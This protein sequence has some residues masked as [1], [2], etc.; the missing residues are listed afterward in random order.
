MD[1]CV[2]RLG[3]E[4]CECSGVNGACEWRRVHEGVYMKACEWARVDRGVRIQVGG[5]PSPGGAGATSMH[6]AV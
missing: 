1:R 6:G 3:M 4:G 5:P 2:W